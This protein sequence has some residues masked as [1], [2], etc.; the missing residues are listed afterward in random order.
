MLNFI[1]DEMDSIGAEGV[2]FIPVFYDM[3][4][5]PI[6]CSYTREEI[7]KQNCYPK[8]NRRYWKIVNGNK[9]YI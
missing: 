9:E 4:M 2:D 6:I 7:E 5:A 1:V 3:K 8:S